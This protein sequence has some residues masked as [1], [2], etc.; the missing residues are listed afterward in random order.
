[1]TSD[2]ISSIK[3]G[4]IHDIWH[5]FMKKYEFWCTKKCPGTEFIYEFIY[6]FMGNH[7]FIYEFMK[8]NDLGST[9]KRPV[10]EFLYMNSYMNSCSHM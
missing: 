6:E 9:K 2:K 4:K 5:E 1:M 7:D 8:K 10:K 3:R